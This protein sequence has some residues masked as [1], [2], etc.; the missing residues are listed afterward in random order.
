MFGC[1][2][3][4]S[5]QG[6]ILSLKLLHPLHPTARLHRVLTAVRLGDLAGERGGRRRR[7]YARGPRH[8]SICGR[9]HRA[10][11]KPIGWCQVRSQSGRQGAEACCSESELQTQSCQRASR[12]LAPRAG[13]KRLQN[14]ATT[15]RLKCD[16]LAR[17][18]GGL[19][20]FVRCI[21]GRLG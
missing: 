5:Y 4:G 17:P 12:G 1:L 2:C 19:R 3:T 15:G 11:A 18:E 13:Q 7:R 21:D 9:A 20:A 8:A 16:A 14:I 6:P 10:S